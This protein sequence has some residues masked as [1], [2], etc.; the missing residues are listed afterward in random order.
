MCIE[1]DK[2]KVGKK[3]LGQRLEDGEMKNRKEKK[4][5]RQINRCRRQKKKK[6]IAKMNAIAEEKEVSG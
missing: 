4:I 2:L 1:L 5:L 3:C 6:E